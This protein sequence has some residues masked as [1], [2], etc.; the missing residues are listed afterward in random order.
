MNS[1]PKNSDAAL[2]A[3]LAKLPSP[4]P[5][6]GLARRVVQNAL[7]PQRRPAPTAWAEAWLQLFLSLANWKI[8]PPFAVLFLVGCLA[9]YLLNRT[10]TP[11]LL[12]YPTYCLTGLASDETLFF[13]TDDCQ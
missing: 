13:N 5:P 7:S 4:P 10:H 2:L 1:T 9:G 12:A 3:A 11:S 6:P 8:V